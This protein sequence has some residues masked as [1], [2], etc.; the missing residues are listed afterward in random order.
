MLGLW[1]AG[2]SVRPLPEQNTARCAETAVE[3]YRGVRPSRHTAGVC[4]RAVTDLALGM[5][6][7]VCAGVAQAHGRDEQR[8]VPFAST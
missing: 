7:P 5:S 3:L 6:A 2:S 8:P 4:T 1:V